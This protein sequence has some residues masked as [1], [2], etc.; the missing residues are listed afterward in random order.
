[1]ESEQDQRWDPAEIGWR[2]RGESA[3]TRCDADRFEGEQVLDRVPQRIEVAANGHVEGAT[4]A[5][6]LTELCRD[7][8]IVW[9][10]WSIGC[11]LSHGA[12]RAEG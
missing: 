8:R 9:E 6:R 2:S 11:S 12:E 1:M 7:E 5:R 10:D 3:S 4:Q